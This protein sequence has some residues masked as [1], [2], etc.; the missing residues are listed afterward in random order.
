MRS[1]KFRPFSSLSSILVSLALVSLATGCP[2]DD[3]GVGDS[4]TTES[5]TQADTGSTADSGTSQD[6]SGDTDSSTGDPVVCQDDPVPP[7]EASQVSISIELTNDTA[8]PTYV[9]ASSHQCTGLSVARDGSDLFLANGST[10]GCECPGP[11]PASYTTMALDPGMTHV[12]GWDGRSLVPYTTREDCMEDEFCGFDSQGSPRPIEPGPVTITIPLYDE[13][14]TFEDFGEFAFQNRCTSPRT[15]SVD[16]ELG[17]ED[18][19]I[20]V[21]LSEL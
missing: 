15:F 4:A 12:F 19:L 2:G 6:T 1:S 9:I 10:C 18:Q 17:T 3:S 14:D 11:E 16:V 20:Q 21:A 8:E 7:P 13:A 5:T